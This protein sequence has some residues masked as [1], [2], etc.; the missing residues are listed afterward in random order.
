MSLVACNVENANNIHDQN[1]II[2]PWL[3]SWKPTPQKIHPTN[4]MS[5]LTDLSMS[6]PNTRVAV[7]AARASSNMWSPCPASCV[8]SLTN[9]GAHLTSFPPGVFDILHITVWVLRECIVFIQRLAVNNGDTILG[10]RPLKILSGH[11]HSQ[12]SAQVSLFWQ[13]EYSHCN[14]GIPSYIGDCMRC[15]ICWVNCF[16][17]WRSQIHE[18]GDAHICEQLYIE[19]QTTGRD[20][21][22]KDVMGDATLSKHIS[23]GKLPRIEEPDNNL[24]QFN[25]SKQASDNDAASQVGILQGNLE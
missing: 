23:S 13:T 2:M 25:A 20:Q 22:H 8:T 21:R 15:N 24:T 3:V 1:E 9:Y 18:S 6:N 10:C 16:T 7:M 5:T 11:Q 14:C 12:Q 19:V 4:T 17:C